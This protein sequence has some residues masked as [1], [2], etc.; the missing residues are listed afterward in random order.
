MVSASLA[1]FGPFQGSSNR[2]FQ[3]SSNRGEQ[4]VQ[5]H[6]ND[7]KYD[8]P[9]DRAKKKAGLCHRPRKGEEFAAFPT[10]RRGDVNACPAHWTG[11][12]EEG[13]RFNT[14]VVSHA[15]ILHHSVN[16]REGQD[17]ARN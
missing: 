15:E 2:P 6:R 5:Q 11:L 10:L 13:V 4:E 8:D 12:A 17:G 16:W 3:G 1:L 14:H 9:F 7:Q